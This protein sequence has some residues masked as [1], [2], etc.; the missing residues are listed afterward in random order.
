MDRRVSQPMGLSVLHDRRLLSTTDGRRMCSTHCMH[1]IVSIPSR[2]NIQKRTMR[3]RTSGRENYTRFFL[4]LWRIRRMFPH[5]SSGGCCNDCK[6][7]NGLHLVV[8]GKWKSIRDW[9][10]LP[11]CQFNG[12]VQSSRKVHIPLI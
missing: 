12:D 7:K 4:F 2:K 9:S 11:E 10:I 8:N 5:D 3:Y 1:R 6:Q